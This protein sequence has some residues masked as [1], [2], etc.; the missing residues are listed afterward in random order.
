M[1]TL[2]TALLS[3]LLATTAGTALAADQRSKSKPVATA[4]PERALPRAMS[5]ELSPVPPPALETGDAAVAAEAAPTAERTATDTAPAVSSGGGQPQ[6]DTLAQVLAKVWRDNPEVLQ[7]ESA[8]KASGYDISSARSGYFPYL[9][10]QTSLAEQTDDSVSTLYFVLP[11]WSGGLTG[12]QVDE[13]KSRQQMA[14]AELVRVRLE[15]GLRAV[16]AYVNVAQAQ[17]Q[18]IQWASYVGALKQLLASVQRRSKEGAAPEADV[19]TAVAR[20]RQA[21][22]GMEGNRAG[23]LINRAQLAQLLLARPG[24]VDWPSE[25]YMLSD[26]EIESAAQR[27]E[28]HPNRILAKAEVEAQEAVA[29]G[30]RAALWPELSL[31]HRRQLEGVVF[32]PSNDATLLVAQFQSNNGLRGYLGYRAEKQRLD[33]ARARADA[34]ERE[35]EATIEVGRTQLAATAMQLQVQA[36]AATAASALVDSFM[37]QYEAGRKTWLEVLNAQREANENLLQSIGLKRN[38][39]YA[40]AKLALEGMYWH[41]LGAQR[42]ELPNTEKGAVDE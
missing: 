18:A 28:L 4:E 13:A 35:I 26:A 8:L 6:L 12:A 17:E 27:K 22:A 38:Y 2:A 1:S 42:I 15:L 25:A 3:G 7:A 41:R 30:A 39:W 33:A 31:Q 37:R 23:L 36:Q 10:V 11:L 32:D 16:E 21:E 20:L 5:S 29:R 34:V 24:S 9:Q 19:Q 40:N 14:A